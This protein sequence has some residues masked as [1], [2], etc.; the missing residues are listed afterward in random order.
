MFQRRSRVASLV[1]IIRSVSSL[2]QTDQFTLS[3]LTRRAP[4]DP[5]PSASTPGALV[6]RRHAR[7]HGTWCCC[8]P[9]TSSSAPTTTALPGLY[10]YHVHPHLSAVHP[11]HASGPCPLLLPTVCDT[12]DGHA[13][14]HADAEGGS[15]GGDREASYRWVVPCRTDNRSKE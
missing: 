6:L 7:R 1:S 10:Y 9:S 13:T 11:A 5:D 15:A 4:W 8:S 12:S 14:R 3:Y 2:Q